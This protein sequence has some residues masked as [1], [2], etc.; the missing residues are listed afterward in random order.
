MV[1]STQI[2]K[3]VAGEA[4]NLVNFDYFDIAEGTGIKNFF[5]FQSYASGAGSSGIKYFLTGDNTI[6]SNKIAEKV[7]STG[8]GIWRDKK[9]VNYDLEFNLPKIIYG[10]ARVSVT[11]GIKVQSG[12]N[13]IQ[14]I[15]ELR[16]VSGGVS[17]IMASGAT[18][19]TEKTASTSSETKNVP[20]DLT[21][22][23]WKFKKGDIL[24]LNTALWEK[25][26]DINSWMGYG[27]DPQDRDDI[28]DTVV[29]IPAG[30]TTQLKLQ[31]P[32][33]IDI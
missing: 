13:D 23:K 17:T 12:T 15:F 26:G 18:V 2:K 19:I 21:S 28:A 10:Q 7:Q 20:L 3:V 8:D 9:N 22:Q 11:Q 31:I 24:R 33:I 29:V 32:F 6:Y 14:V 1:L 25:G 16:K 30:E 27:S 5:A 4:G